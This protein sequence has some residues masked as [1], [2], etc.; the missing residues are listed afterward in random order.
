MCIYISI[1]VCM[2][3]DILY[4]FEGD[5]V[6]EKYRPLAAKV[7][8]YV[9]IYTCIYMYIIIYIYIY[10]YVYIYLYLYVHICGFLQGF[11]YP[12]VI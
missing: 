11:V 7:Y 3:E 4:C 2:F 1:Y 6:S 9:Y 5:V 12:A 10:I 8:I